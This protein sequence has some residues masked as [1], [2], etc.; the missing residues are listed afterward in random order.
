MQKL[1]NQLPE[2]LLQFNTIKHLLHAP[3]Y[4]LKGDSSIEWEVGF[5]NPTGPITIQRFSN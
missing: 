3:A 1:D 5:D 2:C 4:R